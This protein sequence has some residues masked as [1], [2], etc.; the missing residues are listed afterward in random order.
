MYRKIKL[1]WN[2]DL[3]KICLY[4][5]TSLRVENIGTVKLTPI[6]QSLTWQGTVRMYIW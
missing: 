3:M 5:N 6:N 4:R 2:A 1:T